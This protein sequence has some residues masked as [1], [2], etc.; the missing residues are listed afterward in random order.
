MADLAVVQEG[1]PMKADLSKVIM[2]ES[3]APTIP[4]EENP[5]GPVIQEVD[6]S[7]VPTEH[8]HTEECDHG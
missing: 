8:T 2:M 3:L 1:Y 5:G 4:S 7:E 6:P